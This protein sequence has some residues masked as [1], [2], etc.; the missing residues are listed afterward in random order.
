MKKT[1]ISV[2]I[3]TIFGM[4]STTLRAASSLSSR[5]G[6]ELSLSSS[7][8]RKKDEAISR[9]FAKYAEQELNKNSQIEA[10]KKGAIKK[11]A[12]QGIS[13]TPEKT[14]VSSA[15]KH[16][17][18][19]QKQV[20]ANIVTYN[21]IVGQRRKAIMPKVNIAVPYFYNPDLI[22]DGNKD[23]IYSKDKESFSGKR[24]ITNAPTVGDL[25]VEQDL[26]LSSISEARALIEKRRQYTA[27]VDKAL[28]FQI[29]EHTESRFKRIKNLLAIMQYTND[30]KWMAE[31]QG[32]VEG[33]LA[34]YQNEAIKLQ[35]VA[36]LRNAERELIRQQK[37]KRN[38]RILSHHNKQMPT[39]QV[40]YVSKVVP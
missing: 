8:Q 31:L 25:I 39:V 33:T 19:L 17:E 15:Q 32:Y 28:S 18:I 1:I 5:E 30:L 29:F 26:S 38:L 35:M 9:A 36:H 12:A 21:S 11:R 24:M 14:L 27:I 2:V 3:A 6:T 22:Y 23:L 20:K 4:Q 10:K 7:K 37:Y 16:L 40:Q 13:E 34:V